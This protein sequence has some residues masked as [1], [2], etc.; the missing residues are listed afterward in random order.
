MTKLTR[1]NERTRRIKDCKIFNNNSKNKRSNYIQITRIRGYEHSWFVKKKTRTWFPNNYIKTNDDNWAKLLFTD[2][3]GLTHEITTKDANK[4]FWN[5]K[6]RF[7]NNEYPNK[8]MKR[9]FIGKLKD[10]ASGVL[11]V[12]FI[13]YIINR[14]FHGWWARMIFFSI[15][16]WIKIVRA[17]Q[18]GAKMPLE[19][20]TSKN[21]IGHPENMSK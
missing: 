6:D 11:M 2:T 5:S 10:E 21:I 13:M 18:P 4:D 15:N 8:K 3:D 1:K 20:R 16:L 9:I 19:G 12:E 7:D 17:H 14:L